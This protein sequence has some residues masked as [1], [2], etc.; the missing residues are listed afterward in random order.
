[1]AGETVLIVEDDDSLRVALADALSTAGRS[2]ERWLWRGMLALSVPT[3]LAILMAGLHG[4]Q[5]H[6]SALFLTRGE[7][8]ALEWVR[9]ET[10]PD[11][12]LLA[13]PET[14]LFIPAVF[15]PCTMRP[16]IEPI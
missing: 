2:W 1:M 5:T 10:P 4:I 9:T 6:D 13:S 3:N 14:G 7:S 8:R 12:T 16:G 15:M 11:A